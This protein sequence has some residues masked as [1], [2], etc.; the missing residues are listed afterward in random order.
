M[1]HWRRLQLGEGRKVELVKE[2]EGGS[3]QIQG[4]HEHV[5]AS[6]PGRGLGT[7]GRRRWWPKWRKTR[8]WPCLL[9]CPQPRAVPGI[10]LVLN[11]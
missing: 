10:Q 3:H 9:Q 7:A 4:T 6:S 5:V 8:V 11:K 1:G 2:A